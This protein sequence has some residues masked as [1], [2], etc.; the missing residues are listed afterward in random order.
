[1]EPTERE[2]VYLPVGVFITAHAR[3]KTISSAQ[4]CYDRFV[5]ADTDSLH[6][7]GTDYPDGLDIDPFRLGAWKHESTFTRAKFLHAKCYVE[8][9]DGKITTHVAG[10]PANIHE[11]VDFDNFDL[12]SV[13]HGKLYQKRVKGGIVLVPGD[14][15]IRG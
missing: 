9:I 6:I 7:I 1:M 15:Q 12:G 10:M 3:N 4:A 11:Q 5:Y 14:M 13:Y 8:E 2:P